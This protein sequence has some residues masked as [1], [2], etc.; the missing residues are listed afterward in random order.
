MSARIRPAR[1]EEADA[2]S[3]LAQESKA[4]WDYSEEQLAVFRRELTLLAE[5][6]LPHHAHVLESEAGALLGFYTE[7][8]FV[9]PDAQRGGYGRQLL[10]HAAERARALGHT[11]VVIQSDPNAEG[12]YLRQGARLVRRIPSSIPGRSIPFLELPV[13]DLPLLPEGAICPGPERD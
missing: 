12:F 4:V 13:P 5:E 6:T 2:L 3:R 7:H 10:V 9:A 11:S 8:L 1:P